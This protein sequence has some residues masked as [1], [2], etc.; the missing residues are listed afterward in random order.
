M[1]GDIVNLNKYRKA[2]DRA[3]SDKRAEENRVRF[4]RTKA[5]RGAADFE[6]EKQRR[7][8]DDAERQKS[9][10]DAHKPA[11]GDDADDLDPGSVS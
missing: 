5:E 2:K 6:R 10:A 11:T 8:L 1:T 7:A 3:E 9:K 4:G